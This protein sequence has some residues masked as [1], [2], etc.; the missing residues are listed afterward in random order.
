[1]A[2]QIVTLNP[3]ESEVVT[4][5]VT[6]SEARTYQVAVNGLAGSFVATVPLRLVPCVYCGATFTSEEELISHMEAYHPD[7]PYLISGF[8]EEE[9]VET[10]N[11]VIILFKLFVPDIAAYD[12]YYTLNPWLSS[13]VA[14]SRLGGVEPDDPRHTC[15][16][17]FRTPGFCEVVARVLTTKL[18]EP[19]VPL[20]LGQYSVITMCRR[21]LIEEPSARLIWTDFNTGVTVTV[22]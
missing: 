15:G 1:M 16:W 22:V 6:P 12:N 20:P 11:L 3:G 10:G 21:R 13:P 14:R 5:A 19:G 17:P 18:G 8:P 7:L 4:F 9:E 2:E